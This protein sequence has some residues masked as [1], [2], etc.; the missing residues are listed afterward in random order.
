MTFGL[1][2]VRIK[3]GLPDKRELQLTTPQTSFERTLPRLAVS[4]GRS[5]ICRECMQS[6][7]TGAEEE[8]GTHLST[9]AS[10]NSEMSKYISLLECRTPCFRQGMGAASG[11]VV[12][13]CILRPSA[14][15]LP[16]S[17]RK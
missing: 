14:A 8:V 12:G 2:N 9:M 15:E 16:E 11:A 6:G 13:A 5:E 17:G 1:W 3:S 10:R 7:L 4:V